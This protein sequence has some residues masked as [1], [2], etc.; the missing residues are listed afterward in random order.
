MSLT[1]SSP[2]TELIGEEILDEFDLKGNQALAASSFIPEEAQQAVDAAN[3]AKAAQLSVSPGRV[4]RVAQGLNAF[5]KTKVKRANSLPA[6]PTNPSA[7]DPMAQAPLIVVPVTAEPASIPIIRA[8]TGPLPPG[9]P[10]KPAF[11]SLGD[12]EAVIPGLDKKR[13]VTDSVLPKAP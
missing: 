7:S 8:P 2:S 3:A 13:T 1:L 12:P 6:S 10:K 5:R 9:T 4:P 11:K